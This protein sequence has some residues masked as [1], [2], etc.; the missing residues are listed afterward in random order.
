MDSFPEISVSPLTG[1]KK[2]KNIGAL[3]LAHT[4]FQRFVNISE[5][6]RFGEL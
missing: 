4:A 2:Q 5:V 6:K 3:S 1:G